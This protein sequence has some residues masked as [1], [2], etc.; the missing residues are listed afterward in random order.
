MP[1]SQYLADQQLNWF[2]GVGFAAAPVTNLFVS[3]HSA[4]PGSAGVNNDV[5]TTVAAARATLSIA[6]LTA[7]GAGSPSGRAISNTTTIT[8]T[9]SALAGATLTYFGIWSA[10]SGGNFLTYGL[11]SQPIN[12]LTGDII[13][14]PAGL[15]VIRAPGL[16]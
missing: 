4:D 11:L 2:R 16:S 1:H 10:V 6:N 12:V 13:S 3:V 14:F 8:L 7:P 5:T 15:L 9:N